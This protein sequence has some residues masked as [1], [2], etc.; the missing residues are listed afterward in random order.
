MTEVSNVIP[1]KTLSYKSFAGSS[2]EFLECNVD[3][4]GMSD[5]YLLSLPTY[6][7]N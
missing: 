6:L 5:I 3:N 7:S 4:N 1:Q 2:V